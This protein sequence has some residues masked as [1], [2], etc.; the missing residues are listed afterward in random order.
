MPSN[1]IIRK[2]NPA[3]NSW[4]EV[5][6]RILATKN[7]DQFHSNGQHFFGGP[8][9]CFT[10]FCELRNALRQTSRD[11]TEV[12][13]TVSQDAG[14]AFYL[15]DSKILITFQLIAYAEGDAGSVYVGYVPRGIEQTEYR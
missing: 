11:V 5:E 2:L 7:P 13:T 3:F 6:A 10:L 9:E 12:R 4:A 14:A 15:K 1:Q 8:V